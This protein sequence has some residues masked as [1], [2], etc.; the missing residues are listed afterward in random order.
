MRAPEP[1]GYFLPFANDAGGN[2]FYISLLDD[3]YERVYLLTA[4][5]AEKIYVCGSFDEFIAA[6][7]NE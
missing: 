4:D 6:L 5:T 7:Y 2:I 3:D 1:D